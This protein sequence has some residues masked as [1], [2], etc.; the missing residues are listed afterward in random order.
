MPDIDHNDYMEF[1]CWVDRCLFPQDLMEEL[2]AHCGST[3]EEAK[4]IALLFFSWKGTDSKEGKNLSWAYS[5]YCLEPGR[6]KEIINSYL[7]WQYGKWRKLRC[8]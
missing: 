7:K 3:H 4:E 5:N 2:V 6:Y 8:R 1:L